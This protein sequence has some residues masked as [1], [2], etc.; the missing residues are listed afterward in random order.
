MNKL[1]VHS[2]VESNLPYK[3]GDLFIRNN[4]SFEIYI[5]SRT[6]INQVT[7]EGT[8]CTWS[9]VSLRTGAVEYQNDGIDFGIPSR[10]AD[11]IQFHG[12]NMEI[13]VK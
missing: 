5:L 2:R 9:L 1:K 10:L 4:K 11:V 8:H 7:Q 3:E 6:S 12:R 13:V